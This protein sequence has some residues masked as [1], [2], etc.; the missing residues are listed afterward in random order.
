MTR[1]PLGTGGMAIAMVVA[2]WVAGCASGPSPHGTFGGS[3]ADTGATLL[4]PPP[5][6]D[7]T[8]DL[9]MPGYRL[10]AEGDPLITG[11][12][13][14]LSPAQLA[15][16][17]RGRIVFS[18]DYL[19]A[20]GL[21][22]LFNA[23]S[24]TAQSCAGCHSG[25]GAGGAGIPTAKRGALANVSDPNWRMTSA[26][27]YPMLEL[28]GPVMQS[29]TGNPALTAGE[30]DPTPAQ[31]AALVDALPNNA[32]IGR[33][34]ITSRRG[35][36]LVAGNGLIAAISDATLRA[37]ATL[38][39]PFGI[40]GKANEL[41]GTVGD[42]DVTGRVGRL[43]TKAQLP[44]NQ[45]FFA[46]AAVEELGLSTPHHPLENVVNG[47]AVPVATPDLD[48]LDEADAMVFC[49]SLAPVKALK[50]DKA[51]LNALYK[52]G[53]AVCHHPAYTTPKSK[54][55]LPLAVRQF[56]NVLLN[57]P[58]PAYSDLLLHNMGADLADG[59]QQGSA[60]GADWR[61]APLW[62]LRLKPA[63]MHDN[64]I[65]VSAQ[66]GATPDEK[67]RAALE[68]AIQAHQGPGSEANQVVENYL[69]TSTLNPGANLTA[70]ERAALLNFLKNL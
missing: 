28:G 67:L 63:L 55:A 59:F 8:P 49:T 4:E 33:D 37:R 36:T 25:G 3:Q 62:G 15:A 6:A 64:R 11:P 24:A 34:F 22:P 21:G 48:G 14:G 23:R 32:A 40:T 16:F 66:A 5:L 54:T 46:D 1:R 45:A 27:F 17:N 20:D 44:D 2:Q 52:A 12:L 13:A 29:Q 18:R 31:I 68:L 70:K 60:T 30:P 61:T 51:G 47:P 10:Q 58:V 38:A 9:A 69:G 41:A 26:G 39:K 7:L 57:K 43:G 65:R 42:L 50:I 53:C 19:A 35:T 56:A